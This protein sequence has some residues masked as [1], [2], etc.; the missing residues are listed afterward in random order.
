MGHED[1]NDKATLTDGKATFH[2]LYNAPDASLFMRTMA[3]WGYNIADHV[4]PIV[5]RAI[6]TSVAMKP[7]GDT[8]PV[9]LLELCAG[10]GLSMTTV[11]TSHSCAQVYEH[12]GRERSVDIKEAAAADHKFLEQALRPNLPIKVIGADVAENSL[13]Y[14]KS[15]GLFDAVMTDDLERP[16]ASLPP[17]DVSELVAQTKVVVAVGAFSYISVATIKT[18]FEAWPST[19]P[20]FAFFPLAAT[21]MEPISRFLESRGLKIYYERKKHWLPQRR[22]AGDKERAAIEAA[23]EEVLAGSPAPSSRVPGCVHA[24][25]FIAAPDRVDELAAL[26]IGKA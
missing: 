18:L 8:S 25:P 1:D 9:V 26:W 11:R 22:F 5:R 19:P 6:D 13:A 20:V 17:G 15:V 10:Y 24:V 12:F 3:G 23:E 16:G 4:G 2:E 21:N 14:G 7:P